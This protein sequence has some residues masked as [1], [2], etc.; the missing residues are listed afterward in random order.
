MGMN[1]SGISLP[2]PPLRTGIASTAVG[3]PLP[4]PSTSTTTVPSKASR[5]GAPDMPEGRPGAVQHPMSKASR[6]R[7]ASAALQ[8]TLLGRELDWKDRARM[9][10]GAAV[11]SLQ[12]GLERQ[13]QHAGAAIESIVKPV[14]SYLHSAGE[15][16]R[17]VA[18]AAAA[19]TGAAACV[20]ANTQAAATLVQQWKTGAGLLT[21]ALLPAVALA[22][23]AGAVGS[24]ATEYLAPSKPLRELERIGSGPHAQRLAE[25]IDRLHESLPANAH[26]A[27]RPML[28]E[29]LPALERMAEGPDAP[30][31]L[32][33]ARE[34]LR[35]AAGGAGLEQRRPAVLSAIDA[36]AGPHA[37]PVAQ[38][39]H[40][41]C[42]P[43][44]GAA[45]AHNTGALAALAQITAGPDAAAVLDFVSSQLQACPE[46][47][48][49]A[50]LLPKLTAAL[51]VLG[52]LAH[53]AGSTN[54]LGAFHGM[55]RDHPDDSTRGALRLALLDQLPAFGQLFSQP[56]ADARAASSIALEG[57]RVPFGGRGTP[58]MR[59]VA[60]A[61]SQLAATKPT[62]EL[63]RLLGLS[64]PAQAVK[65]WLSKA[66]G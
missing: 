26:E 40:R 15:T 29:A 9:R 6:Q 49:R 66:G 41:L 44:S 39:I 38:L 64:T 42:P 8:V 33:L 1:M 18:A 19:G 63:N 61:V 48:A 62:N 65:F 60:T 21:P 5:Q 46:G 36:L 45:H 4:T 25:V 52:A 14:A 3:N 11:E 16:Q 17:F 13:A 47:S 32:A 51:P 53:S 50:S 7:S 55:L 56:A 20:A 37:P 43:S 57:Y 28:L 59:R 34:L 58:A 24:A 12:A 2:T 10:S 31:M 54:V 35:S 27:M 22:A 30:Q 23:G